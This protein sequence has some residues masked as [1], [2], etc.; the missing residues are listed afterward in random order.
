MVKNAYPSLPEIAYSKTKIGTT[1]VVSYLQSLS[2]SDEIKRAVYII[3]GNESAYGAKGI[4]NNFGGIQADGGKIGRGFDNK[5]VGT[6]VLGE[7]MTGKQ[8]RFVV[9]DRWQTSIDYIVALVSARGLFIGGNAKTYAK[10]QVN[11]V[12]DLARAYWKEYVMGDTKSEPPLSE[13]AHFIAQYAAAVLK[14]KAN[15]VVKV[16]SANKVPTLIIAVFFV[17]GML[18]VSSKKKVDEAA[19]IAYIHALAKL[20]IEHEHVLM[21]IENV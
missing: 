5:V 15:Q 14:F 11:S 8:R 2:V 10:M 6:T 20:R 12:S 16:V 17:L 3:F 19:T 4:N 9:F 18:F 7:N 13:K 21:F 1:E